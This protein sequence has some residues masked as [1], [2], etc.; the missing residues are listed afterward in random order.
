MMINVRWPVNW[1]TTVAGIVAAAPPIVNSLLQAGLIPPPWDS[2]I[3]AV[4]IAL[5]GASA[6][7]SNVTGGTKTQ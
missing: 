3:S 7:D 5:V 4:G 1:K 2:I 6:K